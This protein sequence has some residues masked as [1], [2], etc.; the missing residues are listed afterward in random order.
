MPI[1]YPDIRSLQYPKELGRGPFASQPKGITLHY[2]AD[3][4]LQVAIENAHITG[5]GYHLIIDADGS[6]HQTAYL[7]EKVNHA[8]DAQWLGLSPNRNHVAIAAVSWGALAE[9]PKSTFKAWNGLVIAHS[10]GPIWWPCLL[11]MFSELEAPA[12]GPRRDLLS[13]LS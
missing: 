6:A 7:D 3:D 10:I 11:N 12:S 8:G 2:T 4:S 5:I 13:A 9:N 1:L